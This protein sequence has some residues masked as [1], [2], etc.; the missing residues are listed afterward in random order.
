[1]RL[2]KKVML[3]IM[4]VPLLPAAYAYADD[5]QPNGLGGSFCIHK[6]GSTSNSIPNEADGQDTLDS[7]GSWTSTSQ[8]GTGTEDT[9]SDKGITTTPIPEDLL[10]DT[11]RPKS[12]D[13]LS[14]S[15]GS[16]QDDSDSALLGHNWNSSADND[17]TNSSTSGANLNDSK[18][19]T[20]P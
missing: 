6:D 8:E 5:C 18:T 10:N 11:S 9:L 16:Q 4:L 13:S 2:N 20:W 7:D 1:M 19:K 17:S 3:I 15:S 12:V 14:D